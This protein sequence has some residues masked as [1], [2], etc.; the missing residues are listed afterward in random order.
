MYVDACAR[1]TSG[2][3]ELY[4]SA[5]PKAALEFDLEQRFKAFEMEFSAWAL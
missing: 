2:T 1:P 4:L 3:C 5:N